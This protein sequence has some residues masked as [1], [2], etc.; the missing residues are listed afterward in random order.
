MRQ[1]ERDDKEG[2]SHKAEEKKPEVRPVLEDCKGCDQQQVE[3]GQQD[4]SNNDPGR[5]N[6]PEQAYPCHRSCSAQANS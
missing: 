2:K 1:Q 3:T 4:R 6:L 5:R